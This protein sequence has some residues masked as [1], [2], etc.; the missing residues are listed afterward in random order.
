MQ[1]EAFSLLSLSQLP[2]L[3]VTAPLQ[4]IITSMQLSV[5]P[6][7][8]IYEAVDAKSKELAKLNTSLTVHEKRR[9]E[10]MIRAGNQRPYSAPV[11]EGYVA[12]M[13]GLAQQGYKAFFKGLFFRS[14]H[15]MA[16]YYAFS[17]FT[18]LS[19]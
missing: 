3:I 9:M 14:I 13:R 4:T 11:Y 17:E 18:L 12:A 19:S 10:L 5:K 8:H 6:H 1:K 15:Q 2:A 16:R 7:K